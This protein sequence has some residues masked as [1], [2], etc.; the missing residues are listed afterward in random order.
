MPT[1][2]IYITCAVPEMKTRSFIVLSL[3]TSIMLMVVA[4]YNGFPLVD[5]DTAAYIEQAIYPHFTPDRT[6]F[7][8]FFIKA[9]S[10]H[11][12]LWFTVALQ[13]MLLSFVL[14]RYIRLVYGADTPLSRS[15]TFNL[16]T[17]VTIISFT[18]V[19]W[20]SSGLM[21][22]AF[23]PIL[24]LSLLLFAAEAP[25]AK[26]VLPLYALI[27]FV[28]VSMHFSHI[29]VVVL[30]ALGLLGY[31]YYKKEKAVKQKALLLLLL[32]GGFWGIMSTANAVKKHGFVFARGADV[33]KMAKLDETGILHKY[34]DE[35]CR[36]KNLRICGYTSRLPKS[37]NEFLTSGESP[38]HQMGG[39]DSSASEYKAII[40]DV[41]TTPRYSGM[42]VQKSV[43]S[44]LKQLTR[45]LPP[46]NYVAFNKESEPYKKVRDY[47]PHQS[48][49]FIT[50]MQQAGA[51]TAGSANFVYLLFFIVSSIWLLFFYKE[52][53]TTQLYFVYA[54]LLCFLLANA[55]ITSTFATVTDRFQFRVFWVLPA[56]NAI[57]ILRHYGPRLLSYFNIK[58]SEQES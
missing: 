40:H 22:D 26:F 23:T 48:R 29:A 43:V 45:I 47:F 38:L 55:F 1:V 50:S 53:F 27:I 28:A 14:L 58:T 57:L 21:A 41:F 31:G 17:L 54:V 6:P 34:L 4:L 9:S 35:N 10:L 36:T 42:F 2:N 3:I 15:N 16:L 25:T 37:L 49:E 18:C 8:G 19:S 20:V 7:Y 5:T 52:V 13:S 30:V 24:L 33:Y 44:T 46:E 56:T 11:T 12:S 32:C 51:L 39:W